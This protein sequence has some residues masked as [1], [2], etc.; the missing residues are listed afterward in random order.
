MK[1]TLITGATS[2]IG[3]ATAQTLAQMGFPLILCGRRQERLENLQN[4]LSKITKVIT[5][6]FDISDKKQ[7]QNA[8]DS[9]PNDWKNIEIL[10]NNA[11]NANRLATIQEGDLNDWDLMIDSNVKGI[12]Y[13][14]KFILP[15]MIAQQK[16]HIINIGSLAGQEVYPKGNVYCATKFSVDTITKGMRMDLNA[17]NIKVAAINP[18]LVETEFSLVRFKSD[19]E[20]ASQT[21]KNFQPLTPQDVAEDHSLCC[22]PPCSC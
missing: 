12:L 16:E 22:K 4:E 8:I 5:L 18:G 17:H 21:Y 15:Q 14:T 13:V 20:R 6:N 9:L 1:I 11:R 7:V 3:K 10:I 19:A 2:S